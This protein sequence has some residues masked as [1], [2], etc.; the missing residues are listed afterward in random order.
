MFSKACEYA[1]RSAMCIAAGGRVGER[2]SLKDVSE[3]TGSP[4]AFTAKI[5]QKLVHGEVI[6]SQRG[7]H[8]GFLITPAMAKRIKLSRIVDLIDGD[9][10]YRGCG[11]GLEACDASKP[12]PLHNQFAKVRADLKRMLERTT[13]HS[14][15]DDLP[16]ERLILRR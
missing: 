14:V 9:S 3:R 5:L 1:I 6:D 11:L 2:L 13:L 8:G 16:L 7:P 4:E 10:V 12:C 15:L